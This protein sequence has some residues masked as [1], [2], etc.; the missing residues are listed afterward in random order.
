MYIRYEYY[1]ALYDPV[2]E[3]AF[4]RFS[5]DACRHIDRLTT[6]I[7]GVK[8]LKIAFPT[9]EDSAEAV[10]RCTAAVL[11][12]LIRIDSLEKAAL[13]A[14]EYVQ[15]EN[16]LQKKVISSVTAGNE[17]ISFSSGDAKTVF[18]ASLA[19]TEVRS[20]EIANIV[21]EY[22]SGVTDANGVNLLYMG[23]YPV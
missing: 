5:F 1:K 2:N 14:N 7:D 20:R 23:C 13:S 18:D 12:F 22:L 16:G 11:N 3:K 21:R 17:S 4:T 19:D 8:K 9:D 10:K 6:G 15:T